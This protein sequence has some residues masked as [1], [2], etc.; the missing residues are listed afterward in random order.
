VT[1]DPK[2]WF[3]EE[4]L[5][6]LGEFNEG[7]ETMEAVE[8]NGWKLHGLLLEGAY[9]ATT[10]LMQFDEFAPSAAFELKRRPLDGMTLQAR[11]AHKFEDEHTR[12]FP[13]PYGFPS[14]GC[15][16]LTGMGKA[17]SIARDEF[18]QLD[19][20]FPLS[21]VTQA[22]R[23]DRR[24]PFITRCWAFRDHRP[25]ALI[26]TAD[27]RLLGDENDEFRGTCICC[28]PPTL[29]QLREDPNAYL[30]FRTVVG[31]EIGHYWWDIT[32]EDPPEAL[33]NVEKDGLVEQAV[34]LFSIFLAMYRGY[35]DRRPLTRDEL[36]LAFDKQRFE[37]PDAI[38]HKDE[39]LKAVE[40]FGEHHLRRTYPPQGISFESAGGFEHSD[41]ELDDE[42]VCAIR[43]A[44]KA[45]A[46]KAEAI[47]FASSA[48]VINQ[49]KID[50]F[51]TFHSIPSDELPFWR[52]VDRRAEHL[53]A[54]HKVVSEWREHN[55]GVPTSSEGEVPLGKK[56]EVA[57]ILAHIRLHVGGFGGYG[58]S[59][60]LRT[61]GD[62]ERE[63]DEE[64][65]D[66]ARI[67]A[68]AL[69]AQE[70]AKSKKRFPL[71]VAKVL[72][73]KKAFGLRYLVP[74][75]ERYFHWCAED[76]ACPTAVEKYLAEVHE[77]GHDEVHF[78]FWAEDGIQFRASLSK[79][80]FLE[81]GFDEKELDPEEFDPENEGYFKLFGV[82]EAGRLRLQPVPFR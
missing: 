33:E 3:A 77:L 34:S 72:L 48:A 14:T 25:A 45:I 54:P 20:L 56:L 18:G 52:A 76:P 79:K 10:N 43:D 4:E 40:D 42:A 31:H 9:G 39:I 58:Q 65:R 2:E 73:D 38:E 53:A 16:L 66:L 26:K 82:P 47:P 27:L 51:V 22:I 70:G 17:L 28:Q 44:A 12:Y 23:P 69:H 62:L 24:I 7:W 80:T 32:R 50:H 13:H 35:W 19:Y 21:S 55:V 1:P 8:K 5:R 41:K 64:G 57:R 29:A 30:V 15:K 75:A 37:T 46:E 78:V 61:L 74:Y 11:E 71:D 63:C 6:A 49:R 81:S 67:L 68:L 36:A 60:E 59:Q